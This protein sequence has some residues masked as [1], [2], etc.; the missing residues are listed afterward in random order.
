MRSLLIAA[1]VFSMSLTSF[2]GDWS[3]RVAPYGWGAGIDGSVEVGG[4]TVDFERSFEDILEDLEWGF[5]LSLEANNDDWMVILDG[6]WIELG[7]SGNIGQNV[8]TSDVDE[9]IYTGAIG[10]KLGGTGFYTFVGARHID[11]DVKVALNGEVVPTINQNESLVDPVIGVRGQTAFGDRLGLNWTANI[12]G[13]GTG[14]DFAWEAT[15][16]LDAK[17]AG[18]VSALLGYRILDMDFAEDITADIAMH[19][20]LLGLSASF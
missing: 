12:G 9:T 19:G 17:I 18:P 15:A 14:S 3:A 5:F 8:T 2:A 1:M 4:T 6:A 20:W 13:F 7:G 16:V 10:K 11:I